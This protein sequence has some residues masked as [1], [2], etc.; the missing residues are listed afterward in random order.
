MTQVT[1]ANL[2]FA[3]P[4]HM[5]LPSDAEWGSGMKSGA[6]SPETKEEKHGLTVFSPGVGVLGRR[7]GQTSREMT[8]RD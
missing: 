6:N 2:P 1:S 5:A 4:S 3:E 8:E 7:H